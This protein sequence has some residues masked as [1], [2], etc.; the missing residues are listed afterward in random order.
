M[1][2]EEIIEVAKRSGVSIASG[3]FGSMEQ[4]IACA[5]LI[6]EKQKE[7]D[8]KICEQ[9]IYANGVTCQCAAAIR[10]QGK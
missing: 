10:E 5:R 9:L 4:L 3:Y 2:D 6:A 7:I 1:E 8:A